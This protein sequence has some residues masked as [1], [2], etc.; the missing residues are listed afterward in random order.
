MA[1]TVSPLSTAANNIVRIGNQSQRSLPRAQREF[2]DF[3]RFLDSRRLELEKTPLPDKRKI[4]I[5]ANINI[6]NNFGSAGNLLQNLLGGA[7]DL[8]SFISGMFPGK[9]EKIGKSPNKSKSQP[10][11]TPRGGKLRLGGIRAL[12]IANAIFAGLDFATGLAEGESAGKAGAGALGSFGGAVA[13]SLLAGAVGQALIPVPGVGFVL[14][15]LGGA[16]GGFLGGFGAD[17]AYEA[18]TGS[19]IQQKQEQKLKEQEIA[20]RS[21]ATRTGTETTT[22]SEVLMKF[23]ESVIKFESF[24]ANIGNIMG[25]TTNYENTDEGG[26]NIEPGAAG[27][28][29][30]YD[31][32]V[33]GET[34]N[35][36]PGGVLS[37][38]EVGVQGGEY[39]APRNY[40]GGHSGQDIGGLPPGSPVVA[41]KTGKLSYIGSVE[42]GDTILEIDHGSGVK[43]RYKHVVP[44]VPNGSIVYGGQ[45]VAKLFAT[46]KYDEHLHFEVWKNGSH[47]NPMPYIKAAQ[48]IPGPLSPE[49]AKQNSDKTISR[50]SVESKEVGVNIYPPG[51][52]QTKPLTT[53]AIPPQVSQKTQINPQ[54]NIITQPLPQNVMVSPPRQER[55]IQ[56]YP[57]YSQGQSYIMERQT[58][59]SDMSGTGGRQSPMVIPVGGGSGGQNITV[60]PQVESVVLNSLMKSILLTSLSSS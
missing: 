17:R 36:L 40:P 25:T 16:A 31:G 47:T 13:G 22:F 12:G 42:P 21:S 60:I 9:G 28:T 54:Q 35:P 27:D 55:Q 39:G 34:F 10:K 18:V 5:L 4:Q 44:T 30:P 50:S 43:S 41:W 15:M 6:V 3:A 1:I 20:Q 45:Q 14:G 29:A 11:P 59:V 7:L 56:T 37:T 46:K 26:G 24:A 52:Q 53:A 57:S 38:R 23:N 32:P 49:K 2:Q 19:G 58:I 51:I 48:K 8:G 33:S